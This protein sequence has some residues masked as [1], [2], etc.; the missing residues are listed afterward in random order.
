MA[1]SFGI[2]A[3]LRQ[4][5]RRGRVLTAMDRFI[6]RTHPRELLRLLATFFKFGSITVF[7]QHPTFTSA[8]ITDDTMHLPGDTVHLPA[9]SKSRSLRKLSVTTLS[10]RDVRWESLAEAITSMNLEKLEI[11]CGGGE[12][13]AIDRLLREYHAATA[14]RRNVSVLSLMRADHGHYHQNP[15]LHRLDEFPS[16]RELDLGSDINVS[17]MGLPYVRDLESVRFLSSWDMSVA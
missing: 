15:A 2:P 1:G 17:E 6:H 7:L 5:P 9:F 12:V 16:L 13:C 8:R 10:Y 3:P 4:S 14:L 11:D